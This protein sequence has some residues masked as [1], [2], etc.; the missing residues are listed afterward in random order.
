MPGRKE[1]I[2]YGSRGSSF[3][4]NIGIGNH[5]GRTGKRS[6]N[7][8]NQTI[9]AK[10][11]EQL[12]T[13]VEEITGFELDCDFVRQINRRCGYHRGHRRE[14]DS[15]G[16]GVAGGIEEAR[17]SGGNAHRGNARVRGEGKHRSQVLD[18][19]L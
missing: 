7:E 13:P 17:V 15:N 2:G 6:I 14:L 10:D 8:S 18:R 9:A 4:S 19:V 11:W 1:W 3:F 5:L 12:S 16:E